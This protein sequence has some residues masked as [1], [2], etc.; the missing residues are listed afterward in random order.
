[1]QRNNDPEV[2]GGSQMEK[3]FLIV[4]TFVV[5]LLSCPV[6]LTGILVS[7]ARRF[8]A[9]LRPGLRSSEVLDF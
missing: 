3:R 9:S 5:G 2:E 4:A 1:M 6:V 7:L 8:A